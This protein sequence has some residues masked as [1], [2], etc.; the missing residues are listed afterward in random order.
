MNGQ[1]SSGDTVL[2]NYKLVRLIGEGGYGRVFEARRDDFGVSY[3]AAIKIMTIPKSEAE[4]RSA[5]AEGMDSKSVTAYFRSFVEEI[6]RE[7]ALMSRLKGTANIVSYEDHIVEQHTTGIGWDIIIR[8]ELLTPLF[9]YSTQ[10]PFTRQTVIKLGM[11]MCRAL[12]LCQK[13]N[14]VHRDIKPENIFI[15]EL[16]DFKLGDFGIARTVEKTTSG[17]SKK[18]TYSYMA[19]E[20]YREEAYG[21]GVDIYSLC[22]VLYRLLNDFRAPFISPP[23]AQPTFNDQEMARAKR[24]SGAKLPLPRN[25][26]GRLAEIVLKA[27]AYDPKDRYS[28]PMQMRQELEA[29]LYSR[30]EAPIIYPNG[31][32]APIEPVVY[33][34]TPMP[35]KWRPKMPVIEQTDRLFRSTASPEA[36]GS[37]LYGPA[38]ADPTGSKTENLFGSMSREYPR[39]NSQSG[40]VP[41]VNKAA[42]KP[43]TKPVPDSKSYG[44][45]AA[46]QA[47]KRSKFLLATALISAALTVLFYLA[48]RI[49]F[50]F[51]AHATV[52]VYAALT[53]AV[54]F[55]LY[56]V[57]SRISISSG[58][59][60]S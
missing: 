26:D 2:G 41:P 11:D 13:F 4:I 48:T 9:D 42:V 36:T 5:R 47:P 14:I 58:L 20:V 60:R 40:F 51:M 25:A 7:F 3:S 49:Y 22:L 17:L 30:A 44:N 34:E 12:E 45:F 16:G 1:F 37:M 46:K 55:C 19:P 23:P 52:V 54:F 6:V 38:I 57:L 28:S 8:M 50:G 21:T 33:I 43:E 39:D 59:P 15:S 24:L 53:V 56:F 27:C 10:H 35:D 18:G 32:T 31:D 29:I